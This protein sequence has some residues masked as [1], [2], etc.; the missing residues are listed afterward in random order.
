MTKSRQAEDCRILIID[1]SESNLHL[2]STTLRLSGYSQVWTLQNPLMAKEVVDETKPDLIILDLH[3]PKLSG[4]DILREIKENAAANDFV[5][6]L[7]FTA[8][9]TSQ[10]KEKALSLGASDFLTKPGDATE[11]LLRVGNFLH[12]RIM[13]LDILEHARTLAGRVKERTAELEQSRL[14]TLQCLARSAEYRDDETGHHAQRVGSY[15]AEIAA[16]FGLSD[17]ACDQ[18]RLSAPL[19]D[20]G[21]IGIPDRILLKQGKLDPEEIAVMRTHAEIGARILEDLQSPVL[22]EAHTIALCHHEKWDGSGYPRGLKGP[23]IPLAARIVAIADAFDALISDRPYRAST[24]RE[25]AAKE[26]AACSG[27]HFDPRAVRAFERT[28]LV[29]LS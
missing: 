10:S 3:M 13:H 14:E 16:A 8:D 15:T 28:N 12:A 5:P 6:V 1:D 18:L 2:L 24:T 20:I 17:E 27:S 22:I 11:I 21:K 4:F 9:T 23:A 25:A 26:I 19:H 29:Q 7:V